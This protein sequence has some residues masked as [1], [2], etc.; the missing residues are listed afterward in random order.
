MALT[1]EKA[2]A[3]EEFE[4]ALQKLMDLHKSFDEGQVISGWV[5]IVNGSRALDEELDGEMWTPDDDEFETV[6][7]YCSFTKR[8][9]TPTTS[10][11][12]LEAH[13]DRLKGY[14]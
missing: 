14:M 1:P 13:R 2:A 5:V 7:S 11:G 4:A 10:R 9:Q 12:I 3:Y 6:S 8:G